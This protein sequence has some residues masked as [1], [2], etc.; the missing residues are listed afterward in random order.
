CS[1][2]RQPSRVED[3]TPCGTTEEVSKGPV[4]TISPA[5]REVPGQ[6]WLSAHDP[7]PCVLAG[8]GCL[9]RDRDG[10]RAAQGPSRT[11]LVNCA[12]GVRLGGGGAVECGAQGVD[13][14]EAWDTPFGGGATDQKA[15]AQ[16][17]SI[18]GHGVDDGRNSARN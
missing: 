4:P 6:K 14:G 2:E 16:R 17:A 8:P 11:I 5:G 7:P 3:G 13:A 10:Q 9:G 1:M 12:H 18:A 15:V